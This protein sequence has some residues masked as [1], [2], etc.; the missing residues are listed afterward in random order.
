[1]LDALSQH[2]LVENF[3]TSLSDEPAYCEQLAAN[4]IS[5][6]KGTYDSSISCFRGLTRGWTWLLSVL[7][8]VAGRGR[9]VLQKQSQQSV[10]V[11]NIARRNISRSIPPVVSSNL[12]VVLNF[13][14]PPAPEEGDNLSTSTPTPR[15]HDP[16]DRDTKQRS[17]NWQKKKKK[18]TE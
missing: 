16:T 5:T 15:P 12:L 10:Q 14:P 3:T 8:P 2:H 7:K 9:A 18:H 6:F 1:M 13:L 17:N 4:I 11:Q